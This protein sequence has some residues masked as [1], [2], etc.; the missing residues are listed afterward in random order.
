MKILDNP[1]IKELKSNGGRNQV[2]LLEHNGILYKINILSESYESQSYGRLYVLNKNNELTLLKLINPN[3]DYNID[4]SYRDSY[5]ST[6]F[7]PIINDFKKLIKSF[8]DITSLNK[9]D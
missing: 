7:E 1:G 8:K 3:R 6:S 2:M 9:Q 4:I 5:P